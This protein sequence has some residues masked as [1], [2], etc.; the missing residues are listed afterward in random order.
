[1]QI[2]TQSSSFNIYNQSADKTNQSELIK[3]SRFDSSV[4][5]VKSKGDSINFSSDAKLLAEANR[6]ALQGHE[7][8]VIRSEKVAYLKNQVQAGNYETNSFAIAEGVARE[9]SALFMM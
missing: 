4:N 2:I 7:S 5:S 9:E 8:D 1:M 3:S 6:V